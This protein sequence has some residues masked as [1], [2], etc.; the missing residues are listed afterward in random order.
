[1]L[2]PVIPEAN[3]LGLR[4]A[5]ITTSSSSASTANVTDLNLTARHDGQNP[6]NV[7]DNKQLPT[8]EKDSK[9]KSRGTKVTEDKTPHRFG[10][11]GDDDD[12]VRTAVSRYVNHW[13]HLFPDMRPPDKNFNVPVGGIPPPGNRG[14]IGRRMRSILSPDNPKIQQ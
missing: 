12:I 14:D 13:P 11:Y 5:V 8:P 3:N 1:M 6:S 7:R 4:P 10:V 2:V 9:V